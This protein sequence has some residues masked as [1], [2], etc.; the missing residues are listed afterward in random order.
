MYGENDIY[1]PPEFGD[2]L[3]KV[4]NN[5]THVELK[6]FEDGEHTYIFRDFPE[7]YKDCV[8][9]FLKYHLNISNI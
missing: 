1:T 6:T 5:V 9:T 7:K 3:K 4:L 2:R 8:L